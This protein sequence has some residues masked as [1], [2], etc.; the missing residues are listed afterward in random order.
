M[1]ESGADLMMRRFIR[2]GIKVFE[3]PIQMEHGL[4]AVMF[5][6]PNWNGEVPG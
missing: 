1:S 2:E 6:N 3:R 4:F 5:Q